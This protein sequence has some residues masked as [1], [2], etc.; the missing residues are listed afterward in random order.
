MARSTPFT[1]KD[2]LTLKGKRRHRPIVVSK[3]TFRNCTITQRGN[4]RRKR[5]KIL[6][7]SGL[8]YSKWIKGL[9]EISVRHKSCSTLMEP[10]DCFKI[11]YL[12]EIAAPMEVSVIHSRFTA[13]ILSIS[14][15]F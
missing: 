12:I 14:G 15:T 7:S 13:E 4:I 3:R 2:C 8:R 10:Y 11:L 5:I 6:I 1:S 9:V